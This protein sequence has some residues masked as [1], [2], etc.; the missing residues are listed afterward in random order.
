[1]THDLASKMAS[2]AILANIP[3]LVSTYY[4]LPPDDK[5]PSEMVL[6]GTSGHHGTS[7]EASYNEDHVLAVCQAI[8]EYRQKQ[9][10]DGPLFS[11]AV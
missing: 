11:S 5:N 9:V 6:F 3:G 2:H 7:L 8:C 1:M 4:L 10:I